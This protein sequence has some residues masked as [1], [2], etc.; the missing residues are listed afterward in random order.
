MVR[1]SGPVVGEDFKFSAHS[2]LNCTLNHI[3]LSLQYA[4]CLE[5]CPWKCGSGGAGGGGA[6]DEIT[7]QD[8]TNM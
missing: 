8:P 2:V 1:L 7:V 6:G 4:E 5:T 3:I